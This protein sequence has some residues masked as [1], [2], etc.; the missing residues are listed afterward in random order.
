MAVL[1]SSLAW[2]LF[3]V[4]PSNSILISSTSDAIR[5]LLFIFVALL[6][7]SLYAQLAR[8]KVDIRKHQAR[9]DLALEAGRM[10]VWD[11]D[12]LGDEFWISPEIREIFGVGDGEFSPTY[13]GFLAFV[14]PDD[15]ALVVRAMTTSREN[16]TDYQL[17]HRLIRR[18][19]AVRWIATRGRTFC[20][21]NGRAERMIGLVVDVTELRDGESAAGAGGAR[22]TATAT[23]TAAAPPSATKPD[24]SRSAAGVGGGNRADDRL[25]QHADST[26]TPSSPQPV[27][28]VTLRFA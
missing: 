3:I 2:A 10:G 18:D 19:K 21:E 28:D 12:L 20:D 17:E 14:H 9:L 26:L 11:Y 4:Q 13:G 16:R 1:L 22:A 27:A 24:N 25:E 5:L 23:A 6:T 7:S 15:R 8:A